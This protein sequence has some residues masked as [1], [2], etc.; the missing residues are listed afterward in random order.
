MR[1][2]QPIIVAP[3][4]FKGSL[5]A[6][7][8]AAR[9]AKGIQRAMPDAE[10]RPFP[11]ADGGEGTASVVRQALAGRWEA[12]V[13]EDANGRPREIRY[14]CCANWSLGRFA[15]FDVAEIVGLPDAVATP[16]A[17]TTAG[18][19][20]AIRAIIRRGFKTIVIGLGG[21]STMDAGA[22]LL[23]A[24]AVDLLDGSGQV[25]RPT[26]ASLDS[27]R[28]VSVRPDIKLVQG[29][30]LIGITDVGVPL[31]GPGGAAHV[32]GAQKGFQDLQ[33]AD[34]TL[35][36]FAALCEE[37]LGRS[38]RGLPGSGAAG[39]IGFALAALDGELAPG[40]RFV[41]D[42]VGLP[43]ALKHAGWVITGEGRSD[44]QTLLGKVPGLVA[45]LAKRHGVPVTLISGSFQPSAALD[46]HFDGCFSILNE[47]CDLSSAMAAA[48]ALIEGA[49]YQVG[50]LIRAR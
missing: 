47:L 34:R 6:A 37:V 12:L 19:G 5:S 49:A 27:V 42:A 45:E 11:M 15:I 50:R 25:L 30:S 20:E 48:P 13:V 21:S 44:A 22:G 28:S 43:E 3:D 4:S 35:A 18:V 46:A 33:R 40:A 41:A 36:R 7:E 8:A 32:F 29:I 17:R 39:G 10:V 2:E 31:T 9:M 24:L 1:P 26:F 38:A 14:A 16:E 23:S